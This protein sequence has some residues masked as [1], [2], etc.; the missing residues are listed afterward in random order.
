MRSFSEQLR[1]L[2]QSPDKVE[3]Q[4]EAILMM[5]DVQVIGNYEPTPR[6][7]K[8]QDVEAW[9]KQDDYFST[10]N[11]L[12]KDQRMQLGPE[13]HERHIAMQGEIE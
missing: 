4:I 1:L 13:W 2:L 8:N 7:S 3:D 11:A 6:M 12:R 5:I 10:R 9:I